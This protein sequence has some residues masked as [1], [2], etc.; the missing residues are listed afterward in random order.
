MI[1]LDANV[2]V[3]LVDAHDLHH[4]W[5][6]QFFK[7]TVEEDLAINTLTLAEVLVHPTRAGKA[8][9][10][11][12][13]IKGLGLEV[14]E[15]AA[16]AAPS[17]AETRADSELKMPDAVVLHGALARSSAIAT[18][19]GQLATKARNRGLVVYCK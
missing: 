19:D 12:S 14:L 4:D 3:A 17:L 8:R 5:A 13:N 10:F 1:I 9:K 6:L 16:D 18:L 7:D 15:L 11:L 2:L